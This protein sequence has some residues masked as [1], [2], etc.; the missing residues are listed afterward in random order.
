MS[1]VGHNQISGNRLRAYVA[2]IERIEGEIDELNN[3]KRDVYAEL[4]SE[5]FDPKILRIVMRRRQ[6]DRAELDEAEAL[7]ALYEDALRGSADTDTAPARGR[8]I[9]RVRICPVAGCEAPVGDGKLLCLSHWQRTPKRLRDE[10]WRTWREYQNAR[11]GGPKAAGF[12]AWRDAARNAE[13]W[14]AQDWSEENGA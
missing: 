4:K 11:G 7:V 13:Q 3:D 5:G 12:K 1:G 10:V 14:H 6:V 8:R 2:R 9:M